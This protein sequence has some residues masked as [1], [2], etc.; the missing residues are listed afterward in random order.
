M[1]ESKITRPSSGRAVVP[2]KTAKP[3]ANADPVNKPEW[4]LETPA[5]LYSL[6]AASSES[7]LSAQQ[8]EITMDEFIA[9][10]E[11]LAHLRG[12]EVSAKEAAH[13]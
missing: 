2:K 13:A 9:L 11:H 6:E 7:E 1:P 8:I 3:A 10:K 5:M 12:I 4:L